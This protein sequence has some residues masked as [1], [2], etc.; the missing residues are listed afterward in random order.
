M[1]R[2]LLNLLMALLLSTLMAGCAARA[3]YGGEGVARGDG[4]T[5]VQLRLGLPDV[6][7]DISGDQARFYTPHNRPAAE[8]PWSAPR[9][10]YYISRDFRV[11]FVRGKVTSCGRIEPDR[12]RTILVPLIRREADTH[13]AQ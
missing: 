3:P 7:S 6:V 11:T 2:R 8:W 10:F 13:G 1:C 4:I 12:K 5:D 9:T